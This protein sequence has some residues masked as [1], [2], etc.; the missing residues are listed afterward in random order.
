MKFIED[1]DGTFQSQMKLKRED[2]DKLTWITI[3]KV[4][5]SGLLPV[6]FGGLSGNFRCYFDVAL[7]GNTCKLFWR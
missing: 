3:M 5:V 6:T 7:L 4:Y 1:L 2:G